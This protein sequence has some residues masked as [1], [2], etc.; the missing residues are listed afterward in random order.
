MPGIFEYLIVGGCLVTAVSYL[1]FLAWR[2]S[3]RPTPS[4]G[5]GG[6]S[7]CGD[8]CKPTTSNKH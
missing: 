3:R 2:R 1:T 7:G 8:R 4:G 5:C 6:G